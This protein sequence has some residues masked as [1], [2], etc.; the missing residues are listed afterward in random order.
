MLGETENLLQKYIKDEK[1]K[2]S[3]VGYRKDSKIVLLQQ[4]SDYKEFQRRIDFE[5]NPHVVIN[6]E[7]EPEKMK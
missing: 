1:L 7:K 2:D 6:R 5:K 3:D 4:N